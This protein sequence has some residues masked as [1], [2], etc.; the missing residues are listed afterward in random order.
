MLHSPVSDQ[1]VEKTKIVLTV[2]VI[3]TRINVVLQTKHML[4]NTGASCL[5]SF[6]MTK[7]VGVL[8]WSGGGRVDEIVS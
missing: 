4:R 8:E 2:T 3:I 7:G 1:Y 6:S 5:L